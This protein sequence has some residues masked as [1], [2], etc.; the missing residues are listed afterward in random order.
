M[1]EKHPIAYAFCWLW[2]FALWLAA[3]MGE[4]PFL[5]ALMVGLI[6]FGMAYMMD[7]MSR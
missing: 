2:A 5:S 6:G 3:G 7:D 1:S 4:G